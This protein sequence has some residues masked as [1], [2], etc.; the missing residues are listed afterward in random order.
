[1]FVRSWMTSPV[2][3]I[4]RSATLEEA[5]KVMVSRK[6]RRLPV[7]ESQLLAGIVT[8]SDLRSRGREDRKVEDVMTPAPFTVEPGE[9]LERAA[10]LMLERKVSGL[11]V[12]DGSRLV[13]ILTESDVFR[14]MCQLMG[15]GEKGAR[16]MFTL[17]ESDDLLEAVHRRLAGLVPR[18]LATFHNAKDGTWEVVIR[19]RGREAAKKEMGRADG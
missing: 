9:T 18:S 14:A 17:P 8:L 19:V 4:S 6:V 2:L 12:L 5:E 7:L 10:G 1:M 16:V 13:G 11:P 3:T 15:V